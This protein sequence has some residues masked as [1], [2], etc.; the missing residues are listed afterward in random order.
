[1]HGIYN[2]FEEKIYSCGKIKVGGKIF[3]D[4]ENQCCDS[5]AQPKNVSTGHTKNKCMG[6]YATC[7]AIFPISQHVCAFLV[8]LWSNRGLPFLTSF[9]ASTHLIRSGVGV[10]DNPDQS[11]QNLEQYG[12]SE[13]LYKNFSGDFSIAC[14][15][16]MLI[17]AFSKHVWSLLF[18]ITF[19]KEN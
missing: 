9:V 11:C 15:Q 12:T 4:S 14:R 17:L 10:I 7:F 18:I 1:M 6:Y 16:N 3:L 5:L 2:Q 19:T 8:E 13:V